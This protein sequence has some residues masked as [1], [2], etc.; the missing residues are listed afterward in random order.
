MVDL[1]GNSTTKSFIVDKTAPAFSV[2]SYY[3]A[4]QTVSISITESNF[5]KAT[6]DGKTLSVVNLKTSIATNT[7]ENG[8][9]T[10]VVTDKAGNST[11]K[12]FI[13]DKTA[14]EFTLNEFYNESETVIISIKENNLNYVTFD[15]E[16]TNL[17]S[18][19]AAELDE[20]THTVTALDKAGNSTTK[21]FI[22]DKTA[23]TFDLNAY[24]NASHDIIL[25]IKEINLDYVTLDG[26]KIT[27]YTIATS[28]LTDGTH[29]IIVYDKAGHNTK[30][31]F[32]IDK[33]APAFNLNPYYKAGQ[34][35]SISITES[36]LDVVYLDG[37]EQ[38]SIRRWNSNDLT[39]G[40]HTIKVVDLAGNFTQAA[41]IVDKI[42]PAFNLKAFYNASETV[43]IEITEVNLDTVTFDGERTDLR[44]FSAADLDDGTHTVIVTDLAGNSTSK[45]FIVDKTAPDFSINSYY[46][47]G[48]TIILAITESNLNYVTMTT[49]GTTTA[50]QFS[51]NDLEDGEYTITVVDLAGNVTSKSFIVDKTLPVFSV[52]AFYNASET[53]TLAITEANLN[54]VTLD[55][56][57]ISNNNIRVSELD[58]GTHTITAYDKAGNQ[59]SKAFIVDKTAPVFTLKDFYSANETISLV[60]EEENLDYVTLDGVTVAARS[61]DATTLS[62]GA[63]SITVYDKAKNST[64][65]GFYFKTAQPVLSLRKNG[66][67]ASN[68]VYLAAEDTI[69]VVV[70]DEQFN[71]LTLDGIKVTEL[72]DLGNYQ[73]TKTWLSEELDEGTHT[74]IVYDKASNETSLV[75]SIDRT[76]PTL[77]FKINGT[78]TQGYTYVNDKDNLSFTYSDMNVDR[79]EL[80]GEVT[81]TTQYSVAAL[82]E[83]G[84]AFIVYDKAG[85]FSKVEFYVDKTAPAFNLNAFYNGESDIVLSLIESN[86]DYVTLDG[87]TIPGNVISMSRLNEGEHTVEVYDLAG[88][89]TARSFVLDRTAPAFSVNSYYKASDVILVSVIE[90]N[91]DRITLDGAIVSST[92]WTGT[93]LPEGEHVVTVYDLAGNSTSR[94]FIIDT[95]SPEIVVRKNENVMQSGTMYI[96]KRDIIAV[97]VTDENL[98][99][100]TL[101]GKETTQREFAAADLDDG[102]Y[103]VVAVDLAGNST[104]IY[105]T[106]DK[107]DPILSLR[108]NG[109]NVEDGT[110]FKESTT[111]STLISDVNLDFVLLD[112]VVTDKRSWLASELYE[113]V[114]SVLATDK[115]GNSCSVTFTVDKTAPNITL[116]SYYGAGEEINISE[117][118]DSNF[119]YMTL[120]V[121]S[122]VLYTGGAA[123]WYTENLEECT[124]LLTVYDLAGNS[125]TIYFTVDKTAPEFTLDHYYNGTQNVRIRVSEENLD[126][127]TFDGDVTEQTTYSVSAL[128]DGLHTVIAMDLAGNSTTKTFIV[129]KTSPLIL[130][131]KEY[132]RAS[133]TVTLAITEVNLNTVTLDGKATTETEFDTSLL[134]D[135]THS[136]VVTDLAGNST[137]KTFI[138]DKTAPTFELNAYYNGSETIKIR[139][140]DAN[141]VYILL[142]DDVLESGNIQASTLEDGLHTVIVVDLAGNST[143]KT[144]IVDKT[145]P[146]LY[147]ANYYSVGKNIYLQPIEDNLDRITLDGLVEENDIVLSDELEEG[148]H[149][150]KVYDKAGNSTTAIFIVDKIAP[151]FNLN[152]YYRSIDTISLQIVEENL[153]SVE[154]DGL[155][156][157]L[158]SW[159]CAGLSEGEHSIIVTDYAGN[160]TKK[161]FI[162][163]KTYPVIS[164]TQE[165][166]L[167]D[168]MY[169]TTGADF[170]IE[171][172]EEYLSAVTLNGKSITDFDVIVSVLEDGKY[173]VV[174][175]DRAGNSTSIEF[176]IDKTAPTLTLRRNMNEISSEGVYVSSFDTVSVVVEEINI[177]R[178]LFDG[179][180]TIVYSWTGSSL[181]DG[182]HTVTA[183]DKAGNVT[184][185]SFIVHKGAPEFVLQEYYIAGE[186][187]F[188]D[189][190]E[191]TLDYVTLDGGE[192][193]SRMW[194]AEDL[195]EGLHTISVTDKAGNNTT[196]TFIVDT[197]NPTVVLNK[198]SQDTDGIVYAKAT[199]LI[200]IT[201]SDANLDYVLFDGEVTDK[202]SWECVLLDEK[203]HFIVVSDKA[204]NKTTVSF[205]VDRTAPVFSVKEYYLSGETVFIDVQEKNSDGVYLDN[206]RI[207]V[208]NL[209]ADNLE[210]RTYVL[211]AYDKAGNV[212]AKSFTVDLRAPIL[213]VIGKD[214]S[215][216]LCVIEQNKNSYGEV[217]IAATDIAEYTL[218][219]KQNGDEFIERGLSYT[220]DEKAGNEGVWSVYAVDRNGYKSDVITFTVDKTAPKIVVFDTD[221]DEN[222][223]GYTNTS[224]SISVDDVFP[225]KL[226]IRRENDVDFSLCSQS[227]FEATFENEGTYQFYAVDKNGLESSIREVTLDL[228]APTF[229]LEGLT[230]E[231]ADKGYTNKSFT[232]RASD[233]HFA[234]I[235]YKKAGST[236]TFNT[237]E[238]SLTIENTKENEGTWI[239]YAVDVFEQRSETYNVTLNFTYDFRNIENIRNSFK[240]NTWY[241][242]TL[243]SRIYS[244]TSRPDIAGTYTFAQYDDALAFAIAK[245]KEYRVYAVTEGGYGYVSINNENVYVTYPTETEL[246]AAVFHYAVKYVSERKIFN[247]TEARNVY[248]NIMNTGFEFDVTALTKNEP[249]TP[250]FL[251]EYDLPV[252]FARQSFVPTNN[253]ALSPSSV[254]LTYVGNLT[255]AV[256]PYTFDLNYGESLSAALS[257][258]SNLYEG[259]YIY[260]EKDLCGNE[261]KAILFIDLS[262]P[263]LK[264]YIERG[265]GEEELIINKNAVGDRSGVFYAV[266]F[267][268]ETMFDN[269]DQDYLCVNIVSD[270]YAGTFTVGDELPV[271]NADFGAGL[272]SITVYDRSYNFLTFSVVIAGNAPSWSYTSLAANT[273]KLS[274]YINKNDKNNALL[275]LRIVKIRSDGTYIDLTEDSEGTAITPANSTYVLTEGGKYAAIMIDMYG[276]TVITEPIFY[277]RGLP[278]ATLDGV[279]N[280][281]TTNTEIKITYADTYGLTLYYN[282]GQR[283]PVNGLQPVYNAEKKTF[284]V[285]VEKT[286]DQTIN[287][288]VFVYLLTDEGIYIEYTFTIDCEAPLYSIEANDSSSIA[289]NGS[290][291]KPFSVSW[292]EEGVTAKVQRNGYNSQSY[293]SGTIV[294]L[295]T[296][297]TFEL[298]D[299]VGNVTRFTVYLDSEVSYV[300]SA[301][302]TTQEDGYVLTKN[303]QKITISEEYSIFR[304]TDRNDNEYAE[305]EELAQDGFYRLYV[306]DLYGNVLDLEIEIDLTAPILTLTNVKA[307]GLSNQ[308]VTI[309]CEEP[310]VT[311]EKMTSRGTSDG[312]IESGTTFS[313]ENT[314]YIKATDRAGNSTSYTFTI[315]KVIKYLCSAENGLFTTSTVTFTFNTEDVS[316]V[317][318]VNGEETE[319]SL[320]YSSPGDYVIVLADE[321]GNEET[322]YFSILKERQQKLIIEDTKDF[323]VYKVTLN[324][325]E[326]ASSAKSVSLTESGKYEITLLSAK[327]NKSYYFPVEIDN[328]APE[329]IINQKNGKV[330]FS[331]LTEKDVTFALYKDGVLVEGITDK[332]IVSE[333]G[334][335]VLVLTDECGNVTRYEFEV[336]FTLNAISIALI[337]L[338]AA[339]AVLLIVLFIRGHRIKAA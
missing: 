256:E 252:Y 151:E 127:V 89:S 5:Y 167:V 20:G 193:F 208:T 90:D 204:R 220:I 261:Q 227:T 84:H 339:V 286:P 165:G 233:Y 291:N 194:L 226:Y 12:S 110:H 254:R 328:T 78:I 29:T 97:I 41:F 3:K 235:Y 88:N 111:V 104:T 219:T 316:Q 140:T 21:S 336:K 106:V 184:T 19:S 107:T 25:S 123:T 324:G 49:L 124:Y 333:K 146:I 241:T 285:T 206:E 214:V 182:K 186:T 242:V 334:N 260:E 180:D 168:T 279:R 67:S 212:T 266:S 155:T 121:N 18:F 6:Y 297:Y 290:T 318:T 192:T 43:K 295:N 82:S 37:T 305:G 183:Y 166:E 225:E 238:T 337:A 304:L 160:S 289:A 10:V 154:L 234:A 189:V 325:E 319:A 99:R 170:R 133:E 71:Y 102:L 119:A 185:V 229:T 317:V 149:T 55:G 114:H 70:S 273:K 80:D 117:S 188:L 144:F 200:S 216:N 52:N 190:S 153:R 271:L 246:D 251:S 281:G 237:T 276:R 213:S 62:E 157:D 91:L 27:N 303:P 1:A 181:A 257:R 150:V 83:F 236:E 126:Y 201:I 129:D 101:N 210:E 38:G 312:E 255:G 48:Q 272:Y 250:D 39:N 45:S 162:I 228:G 44:S 282:D 35:V 40:T 145:A 14:P 163:D 249:E 158:T 306:V 77:S 330:S 268:I 178:V 26:N 115:A 197:L 22:V 81:T 307:N 263:T 147:L 59:R 207:F 86:L 159:L 321:A 311:I 332:S 300:F 173:T 15:G 28:T 75:F 92:S 54:Y 2:N 171:I 172:T 247:K 239:L 128:E 196:K 51:A 244:A 131:S 223:K 143:T 222:Q 136:V 310:T 243:P 320:S 79:C 63:H 294:T 314:Y 199:D 187:V 274:I 179:V 95:V 36:N 302:V 50:T 164:I 218:F 230:T 42:A 65:A 224:F 215:G 326:V 69:Q 72:T 24:Y 258:A 68:G 202:R 118:V 137:T 195:G 53:V 130:I 138:V 248:E 205:I 278:S 122:E 287:Y 270:K 120:R 327:T 315:D 156:T 76:A 142:D 259:Y 277:E 139:V 313:E 211:T 46:R 132:F 8:S 34:T 4:G 203:E 30:K 293:Q 87:E 301:S 13:V 94:S 283:T 11:S 174:A 58:D 85:N 284:T 221:E 73:W 335:Y 112:G 31:S 47:A 323:S 64:T 60:V 308:D 309:I 209:L 232:Y 262:E 74:V 33:T 267:S 269:A 175:T 134:D 245:E 264:A 109:A 32:I 253:A 265:D 329:I 103:T 161:S 57:K 9:H 288:L 93:D 56:D 113:G 108:K 16:R 298:S 231:T 148:S 135:G 116:N 100:I 23:P 125:A 191:E 177:D 198:N 61:W 280:G 275:T 296:L 141:S 17:R 217:K 292:L 299:K 152:A 169:F 96:A 240:Q 338:G 331:G 7:L 98:D 176:I 66:K 322:V 105:F